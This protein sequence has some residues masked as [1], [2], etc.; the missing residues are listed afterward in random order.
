[1][2]LKYLLLGV[3]LVVFL[4]NPVDALSCNDVNKANQYAIEGESAET[5]GYVKLERDDFC[6]YKFNNRNSAFSEIIVL[7]ENSNRIFGTNLETSIFSYKTSVYLERNYPTIQPIL[8]DIYNEFITNSHKYSSNI[9]E[10]RDGVEFYS[11]FIKL[12]IPIYGA[13][14]VDAVNAL[15]HLVF[16]TVFHPNWDKVVERYKS[17]KETIDQISI[18]KQKGWVSYDNEVKVFYKNSIAIENFIKAI[19]NKTGSNLHSKFGSL[20]FESVSQEISQASINEVTLI[21]KRV[22]EKRERANTEAGNFDVKLNTL[23]DDIEKSLGKEID[24]SSYEQ[25]YCYYKSN[26]PDR[27]LINKENFQDFIDSSVKSQE[28]IQQNINKLESEMESA[29][30]KFFLWTWFN[31]VRWFFTKLT[32]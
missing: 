9:N 28:D 27:N 14:K 13:L 25:K 8:Q 22:I 19:D 2:K 1:M 21:N 32:C 10:I 24:T 29:K 20:N 4:A 18:V 30:D 15:R 26:K 23:L 7:D 12:D 6:I 5:W 11:K 31:Q 16:N 3:I 17:Y